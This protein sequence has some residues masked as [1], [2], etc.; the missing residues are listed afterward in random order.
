MIGKNVTGQ[1]GRTYKVLQEIGRGGF[2]VVYLVEDEQREKR[3]MKVIAP[4]S[5]P[6]V[7][8]SFE[9]EVKSTLGL[10]HPN[11]LSIIDFG[12]CDVGVQ[13]ALFA[14]SEFCPDG[15]Y[16]RK[17]SGTAPESKDLQAILADFKQILAGLEIL[18]TRII[19]RDLK[20]E[21][22][23]V[24]GQILKLGDFGLAKFVDNATRT[25]T[26]KGAGTPRYM[27]PEVWLAKRSVP[28][29]DLYAIGIMLYEAVVGQAPF[30]APDL[31]V[32]RS[33]HLYTSA[34]RA[35]TINKA[36]PDF[37]DG[38]IRKLLEKDPTQRFQ[39]AKEVLNVLGAPPPQNDSNLAS[40]TER[41]RRAH[42]QQESR[43]LENQRALE[44]ANDTVA[45]NK[46]KEQE[47]LSSLD[48]VVDEINSYLVET[49]IRSTGNNNSKEYHFGGRVLR[50]QFFR[51]NELY[52]NP[53]VPGRM[54]ALKKRHAVHGG[55]IAI[56][57]NGED[58]EGWNVVLLR[59]PDSMYGEWRIVESRVSAI[60]G[61]TPYEP[62]A[63]QA[64]LFADN[65]ACHWLGGMHTWVL[66][67]KVLE[68]SDIVKIFD[69]F[70][71]N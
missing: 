65:V 23:L 70:V 15:D 5:D 27:A 8:L 62:V 50:V 33:M 2:G 16:R 47:L 12:T 7:Q 6:S 25:L 52:S 38:V 11:L 55:F 51:P 21:N 56:T 36:V 31:N 17:I 44:A 18:H 14:V 24:S 49:K 58:R 34:P 66:T 71:P 37:L 3:A 64:Q 9:Q 39:T 32:L 29:T 48:A 28:A 68:R 35:K 60:V 13:K 59:P 40:L 22:I 63:A 10:N 19:H 41:M 57:E 53:I 67:D 54:E 45:F 43:R 61:R 26:F 1:N 69:I 46:Y 30:S 42:D 20:P 4:I